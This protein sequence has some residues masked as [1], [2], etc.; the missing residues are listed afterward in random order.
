MRT[1]TA[2]VSQSGDTHAL[3]VSSSLHF[4][5]LCWSQIIQIV[6]S[7]VANAVTTN[8]Q[9]FVE[10]FPKFDVWTIL[11]LLYAVTAFPLQLT[12]RSLP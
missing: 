5:H 10:P 8:F 4:R 2:R 9:S 1:G 6:N 7:G 11:H 12:A 3:L